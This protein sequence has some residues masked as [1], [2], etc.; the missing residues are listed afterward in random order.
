MHTEATP[1]TQPQARPEPV[2]DTLPE[3][4]VILDASGT[5]D[6]ANPAAERLFDYPL[7]QL[8][9]R[10]FISL[11]AE[12]H[13]GS[14]T[15]ALGRFARG[16]SVPALA[17]RRETVGVRSDGST[18]AIELS[19]TEMSAGEQR[20]LVVMIRDIREQKRAE[21]RLRH[22]AE[23]DPLTG[24]PNRSTF[25]EQLTRHVEYAAR[26]G[27]AGSVVAVGIDNFKYVNDSLGH[28]AGDELLREVAG[29]LQARLRKTDLLARLS[30]DVFALLLHGAGEAK[31]QKVAEELL[32]MLR[33]HSFVLN[34]QAIRVTASAG[35]TA[36]EERPVT[37]AE[38]IA[39][40]DVAMYSAKEGGRD[41]VF[42][43]KPEGREQSELKR[44]WSERVRQ[45]TERGLFVLV[46]QPIVELASG[47][48]TQYEVLLRMRGEDGGLVEP[49]AF[50]STA[51]R[52]GLIQGVDRW[53]TQQAMR[54]IAAHRQE[55]R[56]LMLEV[57][58][59][60]RTMGDPNFTSQVAREL[61]ATGIDPA[62]IVFEVTETAAV[63]DIEQARAFADG[64]TKLGC[65]F[66]L[67]DFGAGYA[68]FYY[69]KHLPISYLKIDG[70]FIKKLPE[71]PT[72]QL[73]VKALVDVCRGLGIK[74]IA[75]FVGSEETMAVLRQLGVDYAQGYHLGK[76]RPVAELR[77][78]DGE[79]V[80]P[81]E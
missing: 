68:S 40:A 37:G 61:T 36:L 56:S 73:I 26:Y 76:P 33:D 17:E 79:A 52:F 69:L 14:L 7:G 3:P 62:S 23:H 63:A 66:A 29:Q 20:L 59:S 24:L 46:C 44:A 60:G 27:N 1:H 9:G 43:Y 53:V 2:I 31:A 10:A 70:E 50:L 38:L 4:I 35:L 65:R 48:E 80:R 18:V 5:L 55:G 51:E 19:V 22:A 15:D 41:R 21:A 45:A 74:T 81:A 47:Q 39:E 64:L 11:L 13:Q 67:D 25:E 32:A 28:E 12:P 72:D 57:N 34:G 71:T 77:R 75:E 54:L 6:Y 49:G 8:P 42:V 78:P 58:L 30:G 16:E